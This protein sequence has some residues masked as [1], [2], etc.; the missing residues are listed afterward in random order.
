M[1]KNDYGNLEDAAARYVLHRLFVQRHAMYIKAVFCFAMSCDD[2]NQNLLVLIC[3]GYLF[4]R[5]T[6]W[7]FQG[8]EASGMSWNKTSTKE[9]TQKSRF[10]VGFWA[11]VGAQLSAG[12]GRPRAF[13]CA[14]TLSRSI[15]GRDKVDHLFYHTMHYI[16]V[17]VYHIVNTV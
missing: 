13:L 9:A 7:P 6:G 12:F 10:A 5:S 14:V 8:L 16:V 17:T 3:L 11:V 2:S 4:E 1:P 15:E